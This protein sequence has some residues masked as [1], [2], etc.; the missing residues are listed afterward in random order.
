VGVQTL[1]WIIFGR[2]KGGERIRDAKGKKESNLL[3]K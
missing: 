1:D 3:E 2:E